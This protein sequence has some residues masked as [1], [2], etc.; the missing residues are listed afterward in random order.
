MQTA[1]LDDLKGVFQHEIPQVN[2]SILC[3]Y[4]PHII[5][6]RNTAEVN[7]TSRSWRHPCKAWKISLAG[8]FWMPKLCKLD[9]QI[10]TE[11]SAKLNPIL[12]WLMAC[13]FVKWKT[14]HS[15]TSDNTEMLAWKLG[16]GRKSVCDLQCR[17]R[18]SKPQILQ[19]VLQAN[20]PGD[21]G[22]V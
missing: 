14:W 16:V 15:L 13:C 21:S 6:A 17:P 8:Q 9:L 3:K 19:I 4:A 11:S 5:W 22:I 20:N 1:G 18:A 7:L 2:D 12:W 10:P